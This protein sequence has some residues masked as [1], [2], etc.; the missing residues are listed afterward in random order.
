[1]STIN[2]QD[3]INNIIKLLPDFPVDETKLLVEIE[4]WE[5]EDVVKSIL[6]FSGCFNN[7]YRTNILCL[8]G[9]LEYHA[10]SLPAF[11]PDG[12]HCMLKYYLLYSINRPLSDVSDYVVFHLSGIRKN[13]KYWQ[14][15]LKV[16]S[17]DEKEIIIYFLG[18]MKNQGEFVKFSDTIMHGVRVWQEEI[19]SDSN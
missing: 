12:F 18:Y 14:D 4:G 11:T 6:Q 16:F 15:R 13:S 1:M 2:K 19:G 3:L 8:E 10:D 7:E 9:V 17:V 5:Y